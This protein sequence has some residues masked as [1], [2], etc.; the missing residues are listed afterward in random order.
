MIGTQI[1]NYR[2]EERLGEG[3]MGV[4]YR[5]VDIN[6][7]RTVA[8]KF[9]STELNRDPGLIERFQ[10]EAKAQANLNHT[11]IATLYN[12]INVDG[13]W[14]I[15]MEYVDGENLEQLIQRVGVMQ[16]QDA[17]PLFKQ[18]LLG[19]GF[20]HRFAIVHRD[21]KPANIMINRHGI[22]KVMDFGIAKAL[23]NR[24][25]TRTG[26]AVG[27][28]AYMSP[29]Q[30][31]NQSVDIRADIY[32]LGITLYQMLTAHLPFESD[33]DFQVQ[34]DHVHTP[35][36]PLSLHYPYIPPGIEAAVLRALEK[37]P[38]SR[39][40]TVEEFGAALEHPD[41]VP[42]Q[43]VVGGI[44]VQGGG[45]RLSVHAG[46]LSSP[47]VQAAGPVRTSEEYLAQ[48][49][50][51]RSSRLGSEFWNSR[52]KMIAAV[53]GLAFATMIG[54]AIWKRPHQAET[55]RPSG[56]ISSGGTSLPV[57]PSKQQTEQ[58]SP[59][60]QPM[61]TLELPSTTKPDLTQHKTAPETLPPQKPPKEKTQ[62]REAPQ[63]SVPGAVALQKAQALY[64]SQH[65]LQPFAN[66]ALFWALQ[67]TADG[68]AEGPEMERRI[69][70]QVHSQFEE[71]LQAQNY[72]QAMSLVNQMEQFYPGRFQAWRSELMK[73]QQATIAANQPRATTST[74]TVPVGTGRSF[75]V[76][77]RHVNKI[78]IF[79]KATPGEPPE[80]YYNGEL[81]ISPTGSV[82]FRCMSVTVQ[83]PCE[84]DI[85][86][87]ASDI[88]SVK[89]SEMLHL[90]T[91]QGNY[92]FRADGHT[93]TEIKDA[94]LQAKHEQH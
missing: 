17:V 41:V 87:A 38:A 80:W 57:A 42:S 92:D 69:Q 54:F 65:L 19:V 30:I 8:L 89:T 60:S 24:K 61:A 81:T 34:F 75:R 40:R 36:P 79:V 50:P 37:D 46:G 52:N 26:V 90:S 73:A 93:M 35:P 71:Y 13:N 6:L 64:A 77:H 86:L 4:V 28:V 23:S 5:A 48:R 22:V 12:F 70:D 1:A 55:S 78:G 83:R 11:N 45:Q 39:F 56:S 72:S 91:I 33:S 88:K 18:A 67:A 58:Q 32:S 25:L 20:A 3:G 66:C 10:A 94:I 27:T 47:A 16:Y 63:A 59:N 31:R 82:R 49:L 14:L 85:E 68:N 15:A 76:Q 21:I 7:E 84:A 53:A 44:P 29:E 51:L 62:K 43:L 2:I 74:T 9:L